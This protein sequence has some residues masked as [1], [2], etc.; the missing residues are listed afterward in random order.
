M[1]FWYSLGDKEWKKGGCWVEETEFES[2]SRAL[3]L[4]LGDSSFAKA[5]DDVLDIF[6]LMAANNSFSKPDGL[7]FIFGLDLDGLGEAVDTFSVAVL[8]ALV[9]E[10]FA[11]A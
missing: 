7:S 9:V 11:T 1:V 2:R 6:R 4:P 10:T 3:N 8:G 5:G